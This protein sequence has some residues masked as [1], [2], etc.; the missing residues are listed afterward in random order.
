MINEALGFKA[1]VKLNE[2]AE[3]QIETYTEFIILKDSPDYSKLSFFST[4]LTPS[5]NFFSYHV[6][7]ELDEI[8]KKYLPG[9]D[10]SVQN[11]DYTVLGEDFKNEEGESLKLGIFTDKAFFNSTVSKLTLMDAFRGIR[12]YSIRQ[13]KTSQE[14]AEYILKP[15]FNALPKEEVFPTILDM[16]ADSW[17]GKAKPE[18]FSSDFESILFSWTVGGSFFNTT[19]LKNFINSVVL[20]AA[21]ERYRDALLNSIKVER[22]TFNLTELDSD[23]ETKVRTFKKMAADGEISEEQASQILDFI[24]QLMFKFR[25]KGSLVKQKADTALAEIMTI[26][27]QAGLTKKLMDL[28]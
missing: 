13:I 23:F 25:P 16:L 7:P 8:F 6:L 19:E 21:F 24:K 18:E 17:T 4:A 1:W 28:L 20:F 11:G 22:T 10:I 9:F 15:E 5:R 26:V 12:S 2:G 14:V 3:S 27:D